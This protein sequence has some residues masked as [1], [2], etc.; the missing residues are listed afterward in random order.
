MAKGLDVDFDCTS[1]LNDIVAAGYDFVCRY[2]ANGDRPKIV[3]PA[4][5]QAIAKAGLALVV[6]WEDGYPTSA[7]YFSFAKGADDATSAFYDALRLG[8]PMS[9]PIYFAVD[10][11]ASQG[12]L[13]GAIFDYFRGIKAGMAA[14][15]ASGA[16]YPIGVYGSGLTCQF[17]IGQGMASYAWLSQSSGFRGSKDY[18]RW[19]IKQGPE[20]TFAGMDI[21]TDEGAD[22][23]GGFSV[24]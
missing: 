17:V 19:N 7:G 6:V 22:D 23:Y 16:S 15:S 8:Q 2:Y 24:A 5:A 4:E 14:S 3:G 9:S 11:D 18:T 21:D 12:E 10:Y 1:H 13:A 20:T